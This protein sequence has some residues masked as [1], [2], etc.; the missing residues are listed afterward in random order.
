M[1]IQYTLLYT[2]DMNQLTQR[3][4]RSTRQ[5]W[6]IAAFEILI[7]GGIGEITVDRI[8]QRTGVSR[9]SFYHFFS[10]RNELLQAILDYWAE[11]WTYSVREQVQALELDPATT[12]LALMRIIRKN[13]AADYDAPIRAW[14]LH[15]PKAREVV[16]Q[17]DEV[18]LDF[19]RSQ[20]QELG[21]SGMDAE[22]R[23]RLFLH[24]EMADPN[25]YYNTSPEHESSLLELR[26]KFLTNLSDQ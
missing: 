7:E 18:R 2:F 24:Y 3:K 9:G 26:H 19:I 6:V 14:A 13:H 23:A 15:D 11:N 4:S 22:N 16:S 25:M 20:F 12:L 8:A 10:D 21:F 17:V 5:D 1:Y